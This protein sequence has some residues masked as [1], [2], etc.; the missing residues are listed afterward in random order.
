[1][2]NSQ[3]SFTYI[4]LFIV[5][6][7][8]YSLNIRAEDKILSLKTV[9]IDAGH[10]GKDAGCI[11]INKKFKEKDIALDIALNLK[12]LIN[13]AYPE[14]KVILTR[15]DDR[16]IELSER[17]RIANEANADLFIS[18]HVNS[19]SVKGRSSSTANGFSIHTLGQSSNKNR[20]LFKAN[21]ELSK[22]ENSVIL[23][24]NDYSTT[25]Q[26][27]NPH[28]TESS[29]FFNLIQNAN[30]EQSVKFAT[31]VNKAMS[32]GPIYNNRGVSQ[33]PFLVLWKTTM[34]SVLI[35]TGFITN[36]K[37]LSVLSSKNGRLQIAKNIFKAFLSFKNE[38]DASFTVYSEK[39]L[40][41]KDTMSEDNMQDS[42]YAI[43]IAALSRKI[44][45]NSA[46]FKSYTVKVVKKGKLY[47]YLI[48][49]SESLDYVKKQS[50]KIKKEFKDSYIVIVK[51]GEVKALNR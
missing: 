29:I 50:E 10:G 46:L 31:E 7:V 23:L 1:M 22:R 16:F 40:E 39:K 47:R 32:K 18:I 51:N 49:P 45:K 14:V 9:C 13:S 17:A 25:Y 15:S 33:D 20:D 8:Q 5:F 3:K 21:M 2:N 38:Y 12:K 30:L 41:Q 24:E 42:F 35:E 27:F 19:V 34:P 48:C 6:L 43:Q 44:S 4:I 11:S 26:G 37:D 28:D 36:K